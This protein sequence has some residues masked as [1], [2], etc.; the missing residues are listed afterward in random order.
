LFCLFILKNE[1]LVLRGK[2]KIK[3]LENKPWKA[4]IGSRPK[5]ER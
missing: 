1:R 5:L 4:M 3:L 2:E